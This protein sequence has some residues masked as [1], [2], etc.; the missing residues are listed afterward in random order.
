MKR[1]WIALLA[2]AGS[3]LVGCQSAAELETPDEDVAGADW[4]TW[5]LVQDAGTIVHG[6]EETDVLVCVNTDCLDLYYDDDTQTL[7]DYAQYPIALEDA[8]SAYQGTSFEDQNGDGN[9]DLT[10]TFVHD[11]GT[12]TVFVWFWDAD[13]GFVYWEDTLDDAEDG[14]ADTEGDDSGEEVI[15]YAATDED[16]AAI[17]PLVGY[18]AYDGADT[19]LRI[20]ADATWQTADAAG[21]IMS[22]GYVVADEA[23]LDLYALNVGL[24]GELQ[25]RADGTLTQVNFDSTFTFTDEA[26]VPEAVLDALG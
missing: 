2:L 10:A 19:W 4:R 25:I 9:S 23:S 7:Y 17:A 1:T 22:G 12:E 13:A 20:Y 11:D 16:L 5:G 18:W 3:L 14:S 6:G 21:G 26:S 24:V 8:P 15:E